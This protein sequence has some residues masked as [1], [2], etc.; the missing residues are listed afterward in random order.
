MLGGSSSINGMVYIRGQREDYQRWVDAGATGWSWD[1]LLHYFRK[2]ENFTG[3]LSQDHGQTGPMKVGRANARHPLSQVMIDT[4][5]GLDI[6]H[7]PE[8][9]NGD[10]FGVYDVLTTAAG[11]TRQSTAR[12]FL[13]DA[14]GRRNLRVM[15]D[16]LV[17]RVL[18][19]N[20]SAVGVEILRHG[21]R[22]QLRA[23][24]TIISAGTI[25]SPAILMR[26]GI[27]PEKHLRALDIPVLAD[28]P[29]GLNLQE[30]CGYTESRFVDVPTYNSP[31]GPLTI[32]RNL[33][34]WL[35]TRSGP[36]AS[37]AV[38]VMGAIR[39]DPGLPEPDLGLNFLP[40]AMD[41]SRG[42]P[43]MHSRPGITVGATCLR[44]DSRGELRLRSRDA[45]AHP[46]ID[47]RLLGDDRD[48]QRLIVAS[49]F[50]DRLFAAEPLSNHIVGH[51]FP[52]SIP[53]NDVEREENVRMLTS[54][55]Y[56]PVGTCRMGGKDAVLDPQLRVRG[57]ANLRVVDASVMPTL[58]SGNTNAVTIAI[59]EKGAD[60]IRAE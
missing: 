17:D 28:L 35:L 26:S 9:C 25:A 24:E 19:E 48:L 36:M 39:S 23:K 16:T 12:T 54:I 13:R 14:S 31:F 27:G 53:V 1:N 11:G 45:N 59:A 32:A 3:V 4:C 44:P 18:V 41:F 8:Y 43:E 50:L 49:R 60:L 7:K 55:G 47:H 51:Y 22:H 56:H 20:G 37:A 29:V 46:I 2:S 30:H 58:I 21:Q 34:Q 33:A 6:P 15:T 5:V 10:Q 57:I 38:Q 40:L 52:V 42:K